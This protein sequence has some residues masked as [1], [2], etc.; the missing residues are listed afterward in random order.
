MQKIEDYAI[1]QR[2]KLWGQRNAENCIVLASDWGADSWLGGAS[3]S[4]FSNVR[5]C[6]R[7]RRSLHSCL[8]CIS[9][10]ASSQRVRRGADAER[11]GLQGMIIIIIR[12]S[13]F[14]QL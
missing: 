5:H 14:S 2:H 9:G 10:T 3:K 12:D 1:T 4:Y 11:Y 13:K 7:H 8:H 6:S